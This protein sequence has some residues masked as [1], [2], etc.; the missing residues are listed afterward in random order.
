MV[1]GSP[2]EEKYRP[3]RDIAGNHQVQ[4]SHGFASGL[5]PNQ[6]LVFLLQL[7]GDQ[8]ISRDFLQR[9]LPLDID[10]SQM[11]AQIDIEQIEDA[12]KQGVFGLLSSAGIMAQQGADPTETLRKAASIIG[13]RQKGVPMHE[14]ILTTFAEPEQ[15]AQKVGGA[16]ANAGNPQQRPPEGMNPLTGGPIGIAPGQQQAGPGGRPDLMTMLAGLGASGQPQLRSAVKRSM[17]A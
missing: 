4:V 17:P 12:L 1:N 7:R 5:N 10:I 8:D 13:L 15:T 6:A 2:F 11:Q 14:A 9:Q 16:A 3:S